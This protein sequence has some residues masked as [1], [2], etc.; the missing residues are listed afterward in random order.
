MTD[1]IKIPTL[2]APNLISGEGKFWYNSD[3]MVAFAR[4]AILLDRIPAT[5]EQDADIENAAP[6]ADPDPIIDDTPDAEIAA[7][8]QTQP[9]DPNADNTVPKLVRALQLLYNPEIKTVED[10][11]EL[12]LPTLQQIL[13]HFDLD[14]ELA[15]ELHNSRMSILHFLIT[16][17]SALLDSATDQIDAVYGQKAN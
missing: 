16:R 15:P 5:L 3:Q 12:L 17:S 8:I 4:Q 14:T 1:E 7:W 2:P 10:L 6:V 13:V 9:N 11:T